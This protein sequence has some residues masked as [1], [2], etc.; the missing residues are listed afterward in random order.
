MNKLNPV[1]TFL[2]LIVEIYKIYQAPKLLKGQF[3]IRSST[4]ISPWNYESFPQ[5]TNFK[6]HYTY[7]IPSVK[8]RMPSN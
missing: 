7:H 4:V 1:S 5:I 6:T 3:L 2:F 8:K